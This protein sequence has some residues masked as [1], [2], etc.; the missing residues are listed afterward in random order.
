MRRARPAKR[1]FTLWELTMVLLVMAIAGTLAVPAFARFGTEQPTRGADGILALLRDARK[2][3]IDYN[4]TVTLRL[5]PK[6]LKYQVDTTTAAGAGV[7][8][9]GVLDMGM[10]E[11]LVSDQPRL[12]YVFRPS[13]ATFA[14]TVA[15]HG[16]DVPLVVRV[17][18]WTGVARADAK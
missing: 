2:A 6:T 14:D 1:G 16:G 3:S 11:T 12:L 18:Q 5:D 10:K 8:A 9:A 13:G 15:V 4:A 17:D 7:L